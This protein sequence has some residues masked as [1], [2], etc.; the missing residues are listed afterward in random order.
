ML[1]VEIICGFFWKCKGV[2][3]FLCI[4]NDLYIFIFVVSGCCMF[5]EK[6]MIKMMV[7]LVCYLF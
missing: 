7:S 5:I 1:K 4:F 3:E 2:M 6:M